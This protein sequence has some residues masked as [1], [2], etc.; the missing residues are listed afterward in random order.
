MHRLE[1]TVNQDQRKRAAAALQQVAHY[2]A[3]LVIVMKGVEKAEHFSDHPGKV[4]VLFLVGAI[5]LALVATHHRLERRFPKAHIPSLINLA[6]SAAFLTA[7]LALLERGRSRISYFFFF[8]ALV[9]A[10]IGA[11]ILLTREEHK[12]TAGR[13]LAL[14]LGLL[15]PLAGS[16]ALVLNRLGSGNPWVYGIGALFWLLGAGLIVV[17]L[18][19]RKALQVAPA[20]GA[21]GAPSQPA[22]Q[23]GGTLHQP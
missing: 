15:F 3:G 12:A 17:Y 19:F 7:G 10:I 22:D 21:T 6:E 23:P 4:I 1:K 2:I 16:V 18:L 9:Y 11:T 20:E 5:V 13:R 14:G 8:I